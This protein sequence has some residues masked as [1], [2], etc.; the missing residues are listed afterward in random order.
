MASYATELGIEAATLA[1][2]CKQQGTTPVAFGSTWAHAVVSI[3]APWVKTGSQV[4]LE[5]ALAWAAGAM[6]R[7]RGWTL[8]FADG[9]TLACVRRTNPSVK[10]TF[11]PAE[12]GDTR[13][14]RRSSHC[15]KIGNTTTGGFVVTDGE[16]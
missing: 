12:A 11:T 14:V 9:A 16:K 5:E 2:V 15:V 13:D 6:G 4:P 10:A 8:R 1:E 3:Q 7:Q